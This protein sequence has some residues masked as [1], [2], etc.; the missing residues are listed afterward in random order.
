MSESIHL[1]TR[2]D[3]L[4]RRASAAAPGDG[5]L[6][7]IGD[8]LAQGYL[9]ALAADA[10]NERLAERLEQLVASVEQPEKALQIRRI[11]L[12]KRAGEANVAILRDRLALLRDQFS[13]LRALPHAG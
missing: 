3:R 7:E 6:E 9:C 4:S 11:L 5:L 2:I 12:Q 13:R 10:R 1:A 8:L